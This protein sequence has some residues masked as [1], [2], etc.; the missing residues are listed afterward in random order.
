MNIR[1]LKKGDLILIVCIAI[2][3]TLALAWNTFSV[4][5]STGHITAVI[6]QDG[7]ILKSIKLNAVNSPEYVTINNHGIK[8]VI[9][10]EKGK[11]KFTE[12]DCPDK[13]CVEAGWL[14]KTGDR[15]VCLPSKTL[16]TII[17]D[18]KQLDSTS[19]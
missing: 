14:T 9:V 7:K 1:L 11:I 15:S 2:I 13:I 10:V 5:N 18:D 6:S 17:G 12:S 4:A 3:A 8:Q 19:Y 16:I